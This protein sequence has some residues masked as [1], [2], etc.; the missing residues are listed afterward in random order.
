M[1]NCIWDGRRFIGDLG[2]TRNIEIQ[3]SATTTETSPLSSNA[4]ARSNVDIRRFS[5]RHRRQPSTS[6]RQKMT[7][8]AMRLRKRS[9]IGGRDWEFATRRLP[10]SREIPFEGDLQLPGNHGIDL[11]DGRSRSPMG[12]PLRRVLSRGGAGMRSRWALRRR[13]EQTIFSGQRPHASS[14]R[15]FP[16]ATRRN[17][18]KRSRENSH[19]TRCSKG[20]L[21]ERPGTKPPPVAAALKTASLTER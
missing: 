17:T 16:W 11:V 8:A 12:K 19:T 2:N 6:T 18:V 13:P 14:N 4:S 1:A 7:D 3:V 15:Q 21:G 20:E 5:K 10:I 9:D